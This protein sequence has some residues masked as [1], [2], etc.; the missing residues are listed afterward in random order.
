MQITNNYSL[1]ESLVNVVSGKR[2]PVTGRYSVSDIIGPP[3]IR[4]LK[5]K[6]WEELS[7]DVSDMMWLILGSSVHYILEKGSPDAGLAEEKMLVRYNEAD[8]V[9]IPD[10]WHDGEISDWKV[11]SVYSFLLGDKPEWTTQLNIYRWMYLANGFE[12]NK[13]I[14]NAILRDWQKSKTYQDPN[15]PPI[16]FHSVDIPIW[17]QIDVIRYLNRWF[18]RLRNEPKCTDEEKWTRPTKW[19]VMKRGQKKALKLF[20]NEK[21]ADYWIKTFLGIDEV[22]KCSIVER[23]GD[24]MRCKDFCPVREV[25]ADNVY[26]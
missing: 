10:L 24:F 25:C 19:A 16:P 18:H 8:I 7:Q 13:L 15:Y 22:K 4:L 6:Y 17:E 26:R 14:I 9:G 3:L 12:T 5:E 21:A 1:P 2:Q 20:D 11:T 23:K